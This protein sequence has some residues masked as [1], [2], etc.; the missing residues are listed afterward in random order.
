MTK[1]TFNTQPA[2]DDLKALEW[3]ELKAS[4]ALKIHGCHSRRGMG[5]KIATN[6]MHMTTTKT[7]RPAV[8]GA[9]ATWG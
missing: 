3:R 4:F 7:R 6:T 9:S 8:T 2:G 5:V 1:A